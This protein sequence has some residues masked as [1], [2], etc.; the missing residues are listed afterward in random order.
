MLGDLFGSLG[1]GVLGQEGVH[2]GGQLGPVE[3]GHPFQHPGQRIVG[4]EDAEQA[5]PVSRPE[6]PRLGSADSVDQGPANQVGAVLG[7]DRAVEGALEDGADQFR[8][9]EVGQGGQV[10]LLGLG[11]RRRL[12]APADPDEVL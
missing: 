2:P 7:A 5:V 10:A 6:V 3:C 9:A 12:E 11:I 1:Q 4:G 8:V